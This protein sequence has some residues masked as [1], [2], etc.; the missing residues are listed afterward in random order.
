MQRAWHAHQQ[1]SAMLLAWSRRRRDRISN[2]FCRGYPP[3]Y[4]VVKLF[5]RLTLRLAKGRRAGEVGSDRDIALVLVAPED[6]LGIFC[7]FTQVLTHIHRSFR[8]ADAPDTL[9]SSHLFSSGSL[10]SASALFGRRCGGSRIFGEGGNRDGQPLRMPPGSQRSLGSH[11][12]CRQ[13]SASGTRYDTA[14]DSTLDEKS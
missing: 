7:L 4:R 12:S 8:L 3:G 6:L 2:R 1:L 9:E 11:E 14:Y 10:N 5:K 13:A